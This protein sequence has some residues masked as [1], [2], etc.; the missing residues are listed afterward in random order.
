MVA[1]HQLSDDVISHLPISQLQTLVIPFQSLP[2]SIS[3]VQF[4]SITYLSIYECNLDELFVLFNNESKLNYLKIQCF[5]LNIKYIRRDDARCFNNSANTLRTLHINENC[6]HLN[7][8]FMLLELTPNLE[9][10]IISSNYE[11]SVINAFQ[12]QNFITSSLSHLKN[13]KFIFYV[14]I[15]SESDINEQSFEE[16]QNDFW[17]NE[18]HWYTEYII[19]ESS[20]LIYTIP[21]CLDVF[22]LPPNGNRYYNQSIN[23]VKTFNNV[24]DLTVPHRT[25]MKNCQYYF[26]NIQ[27]LSLGSPHESYRNYAVDNFSHLNYLQTIINLSNIK[28]LTVL[29]DFCFRTTDIFKEIFKSATQLT[30][31]TIKFSDLFVWFKD[32]ELCK[33]LNKSI[34]KLEI[35]YVSFHNSD[36]FGQ[37]CKTFVNIEHLKCSI[38]HLKTPWLIK[39]LPKLTYL[40]NY[41]QNSKDEI[42][43]IKKEIEKLGLDISAEFS[44]EDYYF[45]LYIWI[46][47]I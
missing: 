47:R 31:L 17:C 26:S 37:F 4:S 45:D 7:C 32:D 2:K 11:L 25:R 13:F 14:D 19:S 8:L 3:N 16:F 21:Y 1:R 46:N 42:C 41:E 6:S 20:A 15:G 18:H 36:E 44:S 40:E 12:W 22:E 43:S 28:H 38:S 5:S 30:S 10:L 35:T 29:Y 23:H 33:Y 24:K 27:S 9:N 34:R 39:H